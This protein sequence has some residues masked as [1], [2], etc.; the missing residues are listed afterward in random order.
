RRAVRGG[1]GAFVFMPRGTAHC[2]QNLEDRPSRILVLLTPAGMER[3]FEEHAN[4]PS[5]PV[6]PARYQEWDLCLATPDVAEQQ[7]PENGRSRRWRQPVAAARPNRGE[8]SCIGGPG[9]PQVH[10]PP[11]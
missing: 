8:K 10:L 7:K 6:D 11:L 4:L 5:G 2:F 3:F 9:T 1:P